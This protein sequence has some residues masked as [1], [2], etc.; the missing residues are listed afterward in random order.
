MAKAK[1]SYPCVNCLV[2]G[3]KRG[4]TRYPPEADGCA[5][6]IICG[7]HWR[8]VPQAWRRRQALFARRFTL[9]E[10]NGDDRAMQVAARC[11]WSGWQ[12]IKRLLT[13]QLT[14]EGLDP[15]MAEGLRKAGLI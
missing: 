15:L 13:E 2:P 1:I 11:W 10:L 14:S 5:P 8:T 12:R 9:A 3:C 4:S 7:P 6:E